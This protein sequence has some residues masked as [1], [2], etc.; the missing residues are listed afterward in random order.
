MAYLQ[1]SVYYNV[2]LTMSLMGSAGIQYNWKY[3]INA[4]NK[5]LLK[6]SHYLLIRAQN[7][8]AELRPQHENYE[9]LCQVTITFSP[10]R[11]QGSGTFLRTYLWYTHLLLIG[12]FTLSK[13]GQMI[14]PP[15]WSQLANQDVS[16]VQLPRG[17][18]GGRELTLYLPLIQNGISIQNGF[19]LV[20][21]YPG[22]SFS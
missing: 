9:H 22:K 4:E 10:I 21:S 11:I 7:A 2:N 1:Q 6:S 12:W 3:Q 5:N 8:G 17:I 13:Y 16:D 14:C 15:F 20:P 19:N 18:W